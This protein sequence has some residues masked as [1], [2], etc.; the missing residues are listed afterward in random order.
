M[1][2][3]QFALLW[4]AEKEHLLSAFLDA[5]SQS[6]V[7]AVASGLGFSP[8]QARGVQEM[9]GLALTDTMYTP[10][11][12]LDGA[13]SIGGRQE[14]Y[15]LFS[16]SGDQLSGEGSLEEAAWEVFHGGSGDSA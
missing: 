6:S 1:T 2:P 9:L 13:A 15:R 5:N 4:R 12:G 10:L 7:A 11:L 3:L 14:S 8:E 16:E